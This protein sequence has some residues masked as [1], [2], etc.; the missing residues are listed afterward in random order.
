MD[1]WL[2]ELRDD[3][4]RLEAD[5]GAPGLRRLRVTHPAGRLIERDGQRLINF[6][7]NDYL[8]LAGHPA[9]AEAVIGAVR[10]YGVGSG[11]SRLITG[12][13]PIHQR[14][15]QRFAQFKH[16]EAALLCPTGYMAAHAAITTLAGPGD[17]IAVDKLCHASLIDAARA[18]G[19]TVRVYPHL[20]LRKARRLLEQHHAASASAS[21]RSRSPRRLIV[22]DSVFSMDGDVAD[23]PAICDLADP[24][25]AIVIVDEAHGTG[26]LGP[27]GAGLCELQGVTERVDVVISTASKALG[28]L[29]G[30]I[31]ARRTVIETLVNRA[32]SFIYTTAVPPAQAA[33]IEAALEVVH[34]EPQRRRRLAQL[35]MQ[36]RQALSQ[37]GLAPEPQPHQPATPIIPILTRTAAGAM[38]LSEILIQ[39]G[40]YAPP[41]RPPTVPRGGSRVRVSLRADLE[42]DDLDRLLAGLDEWR[43]PVTEEAGACPRRI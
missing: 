5:P 23:L 8:G 19:A 40:V 34:A 39:H 15:E 12:H 22:T 13:T 16:A 41:I 25:D 27:T 36:L 31:T 7:G 35:S 42:D 2:R 28:G 21:D 10:A 1:R 6:A 43:G 14:V 4:D 24:Y 3:L 11:A 33:A 17:L 18:S 26:V 30:I 29:G 9:L 32:R 20:Q 37:R 38:E